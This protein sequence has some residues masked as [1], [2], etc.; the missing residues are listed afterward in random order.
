MFFFY[1]QVIEQIHSAM[2]RFALFLVLALSSVID[3][4]MMVDLTHTFDQ[5]AP[6]YPVTPFGLEKL[7]YYKLTPV[8]KRYFGD[9]W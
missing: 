6:K 7:D 4:R 3:G 5:D 9:M 1:K 2:S 8:I